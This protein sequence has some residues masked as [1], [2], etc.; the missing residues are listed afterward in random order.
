MLFSVGKR[1]FINLSSMLCTCTYT[2]SNFNVN[3]EYK[4]DTDV[5]FTQIGTCMFRL[6]CE[7]WMVWQGYADRPWHTY[8]PCWQTGFHSWSVYALSMHHTYCSP[9]M[10]HTQI[11]HIIIIECRTFGGGGI[12]DGIKNVIWTVPPSEQYQLVVTLENNST[13]IIYD[14][15]LVQL[16]V[17]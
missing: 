14:N 3:V 16:C 4:N 9:P 15:G 8:Q 7:T 2:Y 10:H 11:M 17:H 6:G 5:H 13:F 1:I 12:Y